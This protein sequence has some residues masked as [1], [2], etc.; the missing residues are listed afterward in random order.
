VVFQGGAYFRA[1]AK[2]L[3]YGASARAMTIGTA[4]RR[5]EE[6]PHFRQFWIE[7]PKEGENVMNAVALLDTPSATGAYLFAIK[8][9]TE[10]VMDIRSVI[11][12]RKTI[13]EL[14][15]GAMSSMFLH[16]R[17]DRAKVDDFRPEVHDSDGLAMLNG[18][19]E[20]IWRP[21]T[22]PRDLQV[23]SFGM[24]SPKGFG[25]LQRERGFP[26]YEDIEAG[27]EKRP[28]IWVEPIGD[29]GKG[30]VHL[31]E[32]PTTTEYSDNI[33]AFWRPAEAWEPGTSH[34]MDYRLHWS[35][36][37]Q[38]EKPALTHVER[39]MVG[40]N[41][42]KPHRRRFVIDYAPTPQPVVKAVA[43][44][45]VATKAG[46][47]KDAV[48][49]VQ[50]ATP[51]ADTVPVT[52]EVWASAGEIIDAHMVDNPVSSGRRLVFDLDP[53]GANVVELRVVLAADGAPKSETWLFRWTPE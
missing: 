13:D 42:D 7:Q 14:G 8:P 17:A 5:G 6:F 51:V 28:D 46:K 45:A 43:T 21:L 50:E 2:G 48:S 20:W 27:Y 10:T 32:I 33:A 26:S 19:G 52:P 39:T 49:A 34:R 44:K 37:A 16:S 18:N 47:S 22:N 23:S 3:V 40:A 35:A 9:G 12:P 53:K 25:L 30:A 41:V 4:S 24:E 11:F 29:W 38:V 36:G 15:M 31:V 1:L